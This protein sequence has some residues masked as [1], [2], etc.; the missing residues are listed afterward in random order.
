MSGYLNSS[1]TIF[2][3][4]ASASAK[5]T[6]SAMRVTVA[7][8]FG[9]TGG[10]RSS[11]PAKLWRQW[12]LLTVI[13]IAVSLS[14]L[15]QV[16]S[17]QHVVL[18]IDE[19][20][21]FAEVQ[22]NMPWLISKGN[23]NGFANNYHS[24]NGGSLLDYLWLA[25]GSCESAANCTLPPNTNDFGCQGD[26]CAV[27]PITDDNIFREL[28]NSN[29]SWKVYAQSYDAAGGTVDTP[30]NGNNT[31]YYRRHNGATWYSDILNNVDGSQSK[32]VDLGQFAT[33]L[34]NDALPRFVII[35]PD[36]DHDAHDCPNGAAA[37]LQAADAFL[38]Q[39][40]TPM[41]A[42]PYFQPGGDG[43][44]I[45]TFDEC[46]DGTNDGCAAAVYTAVIG[47]KVKSHFVSNTFYQHENTLRTMLDALNIST[48]PGA[49][50]TASPM[51]DFFTTV[52]GGT[53]DHV[54]D[55]NWSCAGN[56][57]AAATDTSVQLDGASKRFT[58]TGGAPFTDA[59]WS[60]NPAGDFTG[61][62][63]FTISFTSQTDNPAASQAFEIHVLR[64]VNGVMYP[65]Q[66]QCDF[67]GSKL[68]R[69][70]DPTIDDWVATDVGC[71]PI[72]PANS[73]DDF[74]MH[75]NIAGSQLHYQ[76][77]VING[78]S[79]PFNVANVNSVPDAGPDSMTVEIKLI[80]DG[81][82]DSYTWWVD[83][84]A[85]SFQP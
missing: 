5:D 17:S 28:N 47:P 39:T 23:A 29:I 4:S 73:W 9:T 42:K 22:A 6:I 55:G 66:I 26:F 75:F 8:H 69:V 18:V 67:Q 51:A 38:N 13:C 19:N 12:L 32:V 83:N 58:Y 40:L 20:H 36:G 45:I 35:V 11:L 3:P 30:D 27:V 53:T 81:T 77:V 31:S 16:P 61:T 41:L 44:L 78:T 25:S 2:Q 37:C 46:G 76:D 85:L 48:H 80:G 65:F 60:T 63:R 54:D 79:Y 10:W 33:D 62:S 14:G 43:M 59:T 84:M 24:D 70:Y 52:S 7:C 82:G 34:A 74:A 72:D 57:L 50:E 21:S 71:A 1:S 68:W 49:S 56:C 15:A 64:R